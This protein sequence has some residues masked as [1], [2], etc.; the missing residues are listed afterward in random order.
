MKQFF[1]RNKDSIKL[2]KVPVNVKKEAEKAFYL[3]DLGFKGAVETG[4]KRA[5]QLSTQ[6]FIPIEDLRFMRNWYA[7]HIY[8]SYP[9]YKKWKESGSK[10][11]KENHKIRSVNSWLTWGGNSGLDFV[12][13]HT[14]LLNKTFGKNYNIIE[15]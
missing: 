4:W 13:K 12:N 9:G 10:T 6:N 14:D 7:R 5:K 3:R 8:T 11:S 2:I 1:G 15:K